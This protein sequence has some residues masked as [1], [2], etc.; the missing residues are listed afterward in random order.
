[1]TL[2]CDPAMVCTISCCAFAT[3]DLIAVATANSCY[4]PTW[5]QLGCSCQH[6]EAACACLPLCVHALL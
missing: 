4:E 3:I 6:A 5:L 1:V 2:A